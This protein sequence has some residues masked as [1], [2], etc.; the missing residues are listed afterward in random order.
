MSSRENCSLTGVNANACRNSCLSLAH[1]FTGFY[2][3]DFVTA[4]NGES[5]DVGEQGRR[6]PPLLGLRCA[7]RTV[8]HGL[9]YSAASVSM[10]T[11]SRF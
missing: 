1:G 6:Q 9:D 11:Y 4:G 3:S 10:S 2:I 8:R 5:F 7:A